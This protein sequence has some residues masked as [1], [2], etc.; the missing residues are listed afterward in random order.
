MEGSS[1]L[2]PLPQPVAGRHVLARP[3]TPILSGRLEDVA[4]HEDMFEDLLESVREAGA[5]LRDEREAARRTRTPN[6][7]VDVAG[8]HR[9][10]PELAP[11]EGDGQK[12]DG[13]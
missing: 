1:R 5:I 12:E 13:A 3:A 10:A 7:P 6:P 8:D 4:V 9:G 11:R 2:P